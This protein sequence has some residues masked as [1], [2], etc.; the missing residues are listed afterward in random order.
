MEFVEHGEDLLRFAKRKNGNQNAPAAP[1]SFFDCL[2]QTAF[3][4]G[5]RPGGGLGVI[6][7]C[8]LHDQDVDLVL[9]KNR[10]LRDCL[11]V[12]IDVAGVENRPAL[13]ANPNSAGTK[14]VTRV[15]KFKG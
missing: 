14:N 6:A 1:K 4:T 13:S 3:L 5:A 15:E 11:I 10:R 12:E 9:G 8:A 7:A 2:G